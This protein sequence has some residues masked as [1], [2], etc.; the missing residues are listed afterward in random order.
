[1]IRGSWDSEGASTKMARRYGRAPRG[2]RLRMA[3]PHGHWMTTRFVGELRLSGMIAPLVIDGPMT[4]TWFEAW[5]RQAL[6]PTLRP[7][8]V[9]IL[10]NLPRAYLACAGNGRGERRRRGPDVWRCARGVRPVRGLGRPYCQRPSRPHRH[11]QGWDGSRL[12]Y[13]TM[14]AADGVGVLGAGGA[15]KKGDQ[16]GPTR[17][18][19]LPRTGPSRRNDQPPDAAPADHRART[20]GCEARTRCGH[21]PG[22]TATAARRRGGRAGIVCERVFGR[23]ERRLWSS[24]GF[25]RLA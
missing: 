9:V 19:F 1:M 13:W 17:S 11:K 23:A 2:E 10:D 8:D 16:R 21:Q 7:G 18:G 15:L 20:P 5:V 6:A 25:G 3:V 22:R 14:L 4:G 24:A 12:H